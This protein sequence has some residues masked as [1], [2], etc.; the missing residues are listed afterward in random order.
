MFFFEEVIVVV[1]YTQPILARLFFFEK[2]ASVYLVLPVDTSDSDR[3][4]FH[5][6]F[7]TP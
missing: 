3:Q 2:K 5:R 7:P 1:T 4:V 6:F